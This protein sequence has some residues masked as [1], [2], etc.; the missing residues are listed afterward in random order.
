[1]AN[2]STSLQT[3]TTGGFYYT[4]N[5]TLDIKTGVILTVVKLPNGNVQASGTPSSVINSL[6]RQR[7]FIRSPAAQTALASAITIVTQEQASLTSQ[8]KQL[9]P[10]PATQP[11]PPAAVVTPNPNN[12]NGTSAGD[13][14]SYD[15]LEAARLNNAKS[16][17]TSGTTTNSNTETSSLTQSSA[18]QNGQAGVGT[19]SSSNVTENNPSTKPGIRPHNPLSLFS[20]YNYQISLYMV[21][22][23]A[24]NVFMRNG[25]TNLVALGSIDPASPGKGGV[26]LVAQSGGQDTAIPRAPGF[27]LDYYIDNV[28]IKSSISSK[29][30]TTASLVSEISFNM[31]EPYGFS[32]P[33]KLKL[34]AAA[35]NNNSSI[36]NVKSNKNATR[37]F[38]IL[39]IRF[40]GYDSKGELL[41]PTN[42]Q[43][44]FF[45]TYYE[46]QIKQFKFKLNGNVTVYD[47]AAAPTGTTVGFGTKH[48][49]VSTGLMVTGDTVENALNGPDG[50]IAKLN[51]QQ[52]QLVNQPGNTRIGAANKYKIEFVGPN[53]DKIK[54]AKL[55]T[56]DDKKNKQIWPMSDAATKA[57]VTDFLSVK[58]SPSNTSRSLAF[59]KDISVQQAI[60]GIISTSDYLTKALKLS[61]KNDIQDPTFSSDTIPLNSNKVVS[62][63]RAICK[64]PTF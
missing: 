36:P 14:S 41:K 63:E 4:I 59:G 55:I 39:G 51:G 29:A 30:T 58:S 13:D 47:I 20:S 38:Y 32:L 49:R 61:F 9:V 52:Q 18:T 40:L 2:I 46:I 5:S 22:P 26:Y 50:L 11:V 27:E 34:A 3:P 19:A 56:D 7:Q 57:Q 60:S 6:N 24:Y 10:P 12:L 15:K 42:P 25:R 48:G 33:T 54:N 28:K 64:A 45:E 44:S 43:D 62:Y 1:V 8:Y 17:S 23:D 31:Y 35:I 16:N 53:A 37:N 21:S